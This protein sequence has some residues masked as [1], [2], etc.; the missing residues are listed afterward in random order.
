M[1]V[2]YF[3]VVNPGS[4]GGE[5]RRL[6]KHIR[7]L[8]ASKK[9]V[10]DYTFT[11]S[12]DDAYTLSSNANQQGYD[13]IVA[14]GGDGTINR[15]IQGFYN[16]Q[17]E[18]LSPAKLGV[19]YTGTSPDFCKNYNI[20]LNFNQALT[21]L[22]KGKSQEITLGKI[23]CARQFNPNLV[24]KPLTKCTRTI[25]YFTCCANIGLGAQLARYANSGIRKWMGDYLGTFLSLMYILVTYR[26]TNYCL[27]LNN[28]E[29]SLTNVHNLA[30]GRTYYIAS[31]IK[32]NTELQQQEKLFYHC[33]VQNLNS[34][35]II[36]CLRTLYGGKRICNQPP[37]VIGY[38]NGV[39]IYGSGRNPEIECDGDPIGFLP[40]RIEPVKESLTLITG[41]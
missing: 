16:D 2:K 38:N 1:Q 17:G 9:I 27:Y 30:V 37:F 3:I 26:S 23:T 28:Q 32:M 8:L 36:S 41:A 7:G 21:T 6:F 11:K 13:V 19:M 39:T 4:R 12:L 34:N 20:P 22:I 15:T 14:I 31:G 33:A 29:V 5:S 24:N 40:C 35:N 10:Y 18:R 25:R